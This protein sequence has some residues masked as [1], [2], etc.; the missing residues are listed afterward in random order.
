MTE[1]APTWAATASSRWL[2]IVLWLIAIPNVITGL[3]AIV[4]PRHWFDTFP[5]WVP[6]L[7]AAHPPF[8]EHLATDAGA[9]LLTVGVLAA[10]AAV[11]RRRDAVVVAGVGVLTFTG[12]HALYHVLNPSDLLSAS[13]DASGTVPLVITALAAVAVVVAGI[14]MGGANR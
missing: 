13:E 14:R 2:T 11:L 10:A 6:H 4:A 3:W 5:G 1:T 7:V 12:P 8:N 9:G